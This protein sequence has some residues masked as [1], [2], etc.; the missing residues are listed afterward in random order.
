MTQ[1][2]DSQGELEVVSRVKFDDK[3]VNVIVS[4]TRMTLIKSSRN[5]HVSISWYLVC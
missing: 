5:L 1:R 3:P 4:L 2:D